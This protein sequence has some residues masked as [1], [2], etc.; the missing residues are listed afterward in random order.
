[1]LPPTVTALL[2]R[3]FDPRGRRYVTGWLSS[4]AAA[5]HAHHPHRLRARSEFGTHRI[6]RQWLTLLE[7]VDALHRVPALPDG[8]LDDLLD[9]LTAAG[10]AWMRTSPTARG[11]GFAHGGVGR[12]IARVMRTAVKRGLFPRVPPEEACNVE[13]SRIWARMKRWAGNTFRRSGSCPCCQ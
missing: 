4:I 9:A 6:L 8:T 3:A 7:T 13:R 12:E 1:M 2:A 11:L 5:V 10:I